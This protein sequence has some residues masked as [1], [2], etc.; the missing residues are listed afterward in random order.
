MSSSGRFGVKRGLDI[1]ITVVSAPLW[2]VLSAF[3]AVLVRVV[4]GSPV[5]FVDMRAGRFGRPFR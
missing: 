2:L 3:V 1:A 4:L 5:I